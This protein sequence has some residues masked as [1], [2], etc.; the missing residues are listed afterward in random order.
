MFVRKFV[1]DLAR[2]MH[3]SRT[4][5]KYRAQNPSELG[6]DQQET[7][8]PIDGLKSYEGTKA[9]LDLISERI[10]VLEARIDGLIDAIG[11]YLPLIIERDEHESSR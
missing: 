4:P 8:Q 9:R 1:R 5:T 7:R 2:I 3:Q 10:R 6:V 11:L